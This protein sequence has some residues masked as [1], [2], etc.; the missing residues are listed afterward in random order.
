MNEAFA[1]LAAIYLGAMIGAGM[2]G[3][4]IAKKHYDHHCTLVGGISSTN[5]SGKVTTLRLC[6]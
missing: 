3:F 1:K 2:V 5:L 6:K 4:G